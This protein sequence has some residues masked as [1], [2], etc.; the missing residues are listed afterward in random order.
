LT[1]NGL[2]RI[3]RRKELRVGRCVLFLLSL[4][5]LVAA[6]VVAQEPVRLGV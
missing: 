1:A 4:A 5:I 3:A 6:P 2:S